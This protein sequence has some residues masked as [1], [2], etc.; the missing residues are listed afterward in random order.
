MDGVY[1]EIEQSYWRAQRMVGCFVR[2]VSQVLISDSEEEGVSR[3]LMSEAQRSICVL[4]T[5]A[6]LN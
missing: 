4:E 6:A 1:I 3:G 2:C 5:P